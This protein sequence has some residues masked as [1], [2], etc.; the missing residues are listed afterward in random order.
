MK[1][2]A[3]GRGNK[4]VELKEVTEDVINTMHG[5]REGGRETRT[6][7]QQEKRLADRVLRKLRGEF[8]HKKATE[9]IKVE[10]FNRYVTRIRTKIRE[11]GFTNPV[12]R[13]QMID[14]AEK[15]P[16]LADRINSILAMDYYQA[17]AELKDF[18]QELKAKEAKGNLPKRQIV[19][20][21]FSKQCL[22]KIDPHILKYLVRSEDEHKE[23]NSLA[24]ERV[25]RYQD[26]DLDRVYDYKKIVSLIP[27]LLT[28]STS[29]DG[30]Q[31]VALGVALATGRRSY[32]VFY[33][34]SFEAKAG[35]KIKVTGFAKK[36][37]GEYGRESVTIP[38]LAD[39]KLVEEAVERL[40]SCER[41]ATL[42]SRIDLV[43]SYD[44]KNEILNNSV[45]KQSN[46]CASRV[47][48]ELISTTD[49]KTVLKWTEGGKRA[50]GVAFKLS[51]DLYV[52]CAYQEYAANGGKVKQDKFIRDSLHHVDIKTANSYKKLH[53][54]EEV[55]ATEVKQTQKIKAEFK[56]MSGERV[57][58]LEEL[59]G[60]KA[61][62]EKKAFIKAMDFVIEQ[63]KADS[64]YTVSTYNL[65]NAIPSET[66][67][68]GFKPVIRPALIGE[69][70]KLIQKS[71]LDQPM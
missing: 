35:R 19:S 55:T 56:D 59:A 66:S 3:G 40:R 44:E 37:A 47:L 51:R 23:K 43:D 4:I 16:E 28:T 61:I 20:E 62:T 22:G 27:E 1:K 38:C 2:K 46:D 49:G 14:M 53:S 64:S 52:N 48:G 31:K 9:F 54:K 63:V 13:N 17:K 26:A 34:S 15:H 29:G 8:G 67:K 32:E 36:K 5:L 57:Q 42:T 6:I 41:I 18:I 25:E 70:V 7:N 24:A 65:R 21:I 10:T 12:Y 33:L 69:F 68:S 30:W 50:T 58:K 71:E 11:A 45:H 60:A 39:P